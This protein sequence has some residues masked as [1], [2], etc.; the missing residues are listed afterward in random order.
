MT[1]TPAE[2]ADTES[3]L[4]AFPTNASG[5]RVGYARVST[6][7][8]LLDRQIAALTAAG[9]VRV[10]SDKKSGK[11]AEREELRATLDYL[12]PGDTLVVPSL[13]RLGRSIQDLISIVGGLR[14]RDIGFQSLHEALDTTTPGGRLVF[15]VFAAL[16][17]FIRELIV[18]GTHEGLEAA[19]ARGERIGRPPAMTE[20]QIRHARALLAQPENTV[21]SIAKL[22]GVSRTT[23]YKYVPELRVG[24]DA[25][26]AGDRGPALPG[27]R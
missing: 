24:R 4:E 13:D 7:G 23:L 3:P 14:K 10:F 22:L 17:E 20:E 16:A 18:Q 12:R 27:P 26:V 15:H 11:D 19:R 5:A 21:T 9:C 25:L 2:W 6:K 1:T 8:Q